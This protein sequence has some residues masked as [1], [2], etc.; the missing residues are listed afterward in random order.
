MT[1]NLPA[2]REAAAGA[3]LD[4][5]TDSWVRVVVPVAELAAQVA[6]TE[7]V[8]RGLRGSAPA[9]AAAILYGREV[10]L[11]PMSALA[12][13]HVVEGRPG[14]S[15]EGMRA[16]VLQAGHELEVTEASGAMVTM[17]GRRRGADR[18]T[19]LSWS[20]D[21][22]RAA[23]VAGKAVWQRYPRAMLL[24][25]C[26][27]DLCRMI[28]PDVI[29]GMR[30]TEE[31]DDLQD[32]DAPAAAIEAPAQP[33]TKVTRKRTS[34][35]R[36][37][38]AAP[39]GKAPDGAHAPA[40]P[41]LP[42]EPGYDDLTAAAKPAAADTEHPAGGVDSASGDGFRGDDV[43]TGEDAEH[44]AS[45]AGPDAA[46][47]DRDE[48][49]VAV[50]DEAAREGGAG[51]E[52]PGAAAPDPGKEPTASEQPKADRDAT[53]PIQPGVRRAVMAQFGRFELTDDSDRDERLNIVSTIAEREVDSTNRLTQ[54]E[55]K[56]IADT[57]ARFRDRPALYE[58][59]DALDGD[60]QARRE[61]ADTPL[62]DA[63][64]G[65]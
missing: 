47:D 3:E 65:E 19:E 16:L 60:R 51:R 9:V 63:D 55:G 54:A 22:A 18:W 38:T 58:F 26:T 10:G 30:S 42:G 23:G 50:P 27:T 28:F 34:R 43:A 7:F 8:P 46:A 45:P 13:T 61:L 1:D 64:G 56:V 39:A 4:A 20:L 52:E 33:T 48:A 31:L 53:R 59:L 14:I 25:R 35:A 41:P 44:A 12:M 36:K 32:V 37:S 62:P 49:G 5:A 21:M 57:L 2:I 11:P 24:A 6:D 29:H 15:A 17:R 40:G